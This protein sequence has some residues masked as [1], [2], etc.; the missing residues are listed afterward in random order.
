MYTHPTWALWG[1]TRYKDDLNFPLTM[2]FTTPRHLQPCFSN[3]AIAI[4]IMSST[5]F[6]LTSTLTTAV[7]NLPP[8]DEIPTA[9][10]MQL[11]G[12]INQLQAQLEPIQIPLQR[13]CFS[14]C[15]PRN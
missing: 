7:S 12:I 9:E 13:F 5:I 8:P 1:K 6:D 10:R 4:A 11:L 15:T 3:I 2:C 14:V